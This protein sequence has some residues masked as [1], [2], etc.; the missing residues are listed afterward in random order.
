[1]EKA[2]DNQV[3][4][5][6]RRL[7][8]KQSVANILMEKGFATVEK[9]CIETLTEMIQSCTYWMFLWFRIIFP[10]FIDLILHTHTVITEIGQSSR[11]YCEL[12][13][14]TQPV[15]GDVI[16]ALINA[17]IS[18]Q[19]LDT[20]AKRENRAILQ[21]PQQ[22]SSTKQLSLLQAGTK[23]SHPSHI[24]NH[25]PVL[26]DPHAYIRTPVCWRIDTKMK[27]NSKILPSSNWHI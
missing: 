5:N 4:G 19:G 17:G 18:I 22:I 10:Q 27:N 25:L 26:P 14:R 21:P 16:V 11:N 8:L 12:S 7:V 9:Q 3:I 6:P 1:M 2:Q 20:F 13:G 23:N 24:P 15:I